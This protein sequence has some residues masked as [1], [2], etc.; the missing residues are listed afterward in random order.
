M[1]S[2]APFESE[3]FLPLSPAPRGPSEHPARA[4]AIRTNKR[5][6]MRGLIRI[7]GAAGRETPPALPPIRLLR[8]A[9]E[10]HEHEQDGEDHRAERPDFRESDLHARPPAAFLRLPSLPPARAGATSCTTIFWS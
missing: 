6:C 1:N 4:P 2:S 3:G 8:D 9:A 10:V 7:V 5:S